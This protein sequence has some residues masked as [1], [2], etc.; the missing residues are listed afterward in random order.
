MGEGK[1]VNI[2]TKINMIIQG[3]NKEREKRS[4]L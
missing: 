3:K 1:Q 2:Q 4:N